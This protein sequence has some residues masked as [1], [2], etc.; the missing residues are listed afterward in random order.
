MKNRI[1]TI[2]LFL[3]LFST[4]NYAQAGLKLT[5]ILF[6]PP[7]GAA[8][9]ATSGDA[10]GDGTREPNSD[11]FFELF[12]ST[13]KSIDISGYQMVE[14]EGVAIYTFPVGTII[15][16]N[17]YAVVFGNVRSTGFGPN[18]PAGQ[19]YLAKEHQDANVGF[20]PV[21]TSTGSKTNWSNTSDRVMIVNPLLA[22]TLVE[23]YW[24]GSNIVGGPM[25]IK[26]LTKK[27]IYLAGA[28]TVLGDSIISITKGGSIK[29]S[30]HLDMSTGKWGLHTTVSN[31]ANSLLSPGRDAKSATA[32][33]ENI[34][35][36]PTD[37]QLFQ[38]YPNPFNPNTNIKF[39]LANQ[40][41]V[42]I[43]IYNLVG[44]Q[45]A[46]LMNKD[47]GAGLYLL[48]FDAKNLPSGIYIYS[49]ESGN[50][51]SAKKMILLK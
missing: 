29:Q 47:L 7:S 46:L 33:E 17:Q 26:P 22:D 34:S 35:S 9:T 44:E 40:N 14:R 4:L 38:N 24:G 15:K 41:H 13:T 10:N 37:F 3:A 39:S 45:V 8:G 18:L 51:K 23:V 43:T 12:N 16:A 50:Y 2:A 27:A 28:N 1:L 30:V 31:N 36:V 32:V 48:N 19:L 6:D 25:P 5:E 11:E 20:G 49:F 42:K 21:T